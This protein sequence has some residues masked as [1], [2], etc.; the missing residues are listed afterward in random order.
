MIEF[1]K[2]VTPEDWGYLATLRQVTEKTMLKSGF[3]TR[4]QLDRGRMELVQ[5]FRR[6]TMWLARTEDEVVGAIGLDG[7]DTRLWDDD[8]DYTGAL[9]L[10]KVMAVPGHNI[11]EKLVRFAEF[12]A[13]M[14]GMRRLRLDCLRGNTKLQGFWKDQGFEHL[15]D[16]T[17]G[18][19]TAGA[20]FEKKLS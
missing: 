4:E 5:R 12:Q 3:Y 10:Y 7:P 2:A 18:D 11:G 8:P 15:R 16:V 13:R 1:I 20:L 19:Y 14:K 9:Y 17:V 6:G